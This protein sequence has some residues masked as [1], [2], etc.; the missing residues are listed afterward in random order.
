MGQQSFIGRGT[1][2]RSVDEL[3]NLLGEWLK[4][5]E[6]TIGDVGSYGGKAWIHVRTPGGDFVLNADTTRDG[7]R[8]FIELHRQGLKLQLIPNAQGALN[9]LTNEPDKRPIKG[10]YMYT[11]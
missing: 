11:A 5:N 4:T 9:K 8:R 10:H 7:V 6:R 1:V 3:V 2:C